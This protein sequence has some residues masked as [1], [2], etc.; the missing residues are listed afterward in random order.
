MMTRWALALIL[1]LM[2]AIPSHAI[3]DTQRIT[4]DKVIDALAGQGYELRSVTR[5]LLGRARIV[6]SQGLIWREVVLD[7][8]AGRILRDYAVEFTPTN[9]PETAQKSMPRG[10]KLIAESQF[11]EL[12]P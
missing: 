7:T 8:S 6:A 5:T 2:L 10:G 4:T 1:V 12:D 11:N 9:A 3:A